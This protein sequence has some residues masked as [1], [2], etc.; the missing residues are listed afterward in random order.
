[1]EYKCK[2]EK[3]FCISHLQAEIHNCTYNYKSDGIN[4]L[5][6]QMEIGTLKDKLESRI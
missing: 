4:I 3:K 1:M 2:C 6:K 5:K